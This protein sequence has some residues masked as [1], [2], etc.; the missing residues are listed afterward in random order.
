MLIFDILDDGIPAVKWSASNYLGKYIGI[1]VPSVI[2]DLVAIAWSI[3]D[4]EPQADS[5]L[6][7]NYHKYKRTQQPFQEGNTYH[8]RLDGFPWSIERSLKGSD[9]L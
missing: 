7:N 3:D 5:I 1:S 6:L 8:G 9:G 4:V 2:V